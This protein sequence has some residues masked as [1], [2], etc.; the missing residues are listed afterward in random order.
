MPER[1]DLLAR[2]LAGAP[3]WVLSGSLTGW[4]DPLIPRF[5]LVVFLHVAPETRLARLLQR[6]RQR[7]GADI[8]PG[9][10]LHEQHRAFVEWARGYDRPDFDGRSLAGHR[11]WLAALPCPV[12]EF[13]GTTPLEELVAQLV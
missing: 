10:R 7:F 6:E 2:A 13:D 11:A 5:D 8:E 3:R 9:G 1:L 4:G 12:V